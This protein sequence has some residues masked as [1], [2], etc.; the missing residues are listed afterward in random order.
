MPGNTGVKGFQCTD[1]SHIPEELK[2]RDR[3]F[4]YFPS[5]AMLPFLRALDVHNGK[6]ER[7]HF[8]E[9]WFTDD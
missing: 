3:G 5:S 1:K 6:C 2:Y 8:Q 9:V 4:M 7:F